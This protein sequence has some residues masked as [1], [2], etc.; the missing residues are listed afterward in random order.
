MVR[1]AFPTLALVF[2]AC[3]PTDNPLQPA[4]PS[5]PRSTVAGSV[6]YEAIDLGTL[7]GDSSVPTALNDRGQIVGWS[8]TAGGNQRAFLWE[9]G[10]MHELPTLGGE[11]IATSINDAGLIAGTSR[12]FCDGCGSVRLV[13]WRNAVIRDLGVSEDFERSRIDGV[14]A[15][16]DILV[17]LLPAEYDGR[18]ALWHD[19]V[20]QELGHLPNGWNWT[21]AHAL[22]DRRQWSARAPPSRTT[23]APSST[24]SCGRTA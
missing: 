2:A 10:V 7:G 23:S 4:P 17:S 13:T 5:A 1:R 22:N 20:L 15:R 19:G 11:T 3:W 6:G 8:L 24:R 9:N 21:Y 12:E 18:A 16:G 14:N